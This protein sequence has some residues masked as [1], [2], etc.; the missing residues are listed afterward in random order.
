MIKYPFKK[1]EDDD[2]KIKPK[3]GNK[4]PSKSKSRH[5]SSDVNFLFN[6]NFY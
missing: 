5:H 2:Y 4:S 3:A 6:L 1:D